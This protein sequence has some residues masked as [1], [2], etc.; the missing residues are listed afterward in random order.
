MV[1]T[2][3]AFMCGWRQFVLWLYSNGSTNILCT[4]KIF[5]G[6]CC[7]WLRKIPKMLLHEEG[8]QDCCTTNKTFDLHFHLYNEFTSIFFTLESKLSAVRLDNKQEA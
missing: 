2:I 5:H 1:P 4:R 3:I 6:Q 7:S 8:K